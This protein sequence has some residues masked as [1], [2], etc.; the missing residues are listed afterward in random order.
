MDQDAAANR[1]D[2]PRTGPGGAAAANPS[3]AGSTGL[4][5][6]GIRDAAGLVVL[7][8]LEIVSRYA[9][10]ADGADVVELLARV[11]REAAVA[12]RC[13]RLVFAYPQWL[14]L[15]AAHSARVRQG[16]AG[17]AEVRGAEPTA[18]ADDQYV[19]AAAAGPVEHAEDRS[20]QP[21]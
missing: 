1:G 20:Q 6:F 12:A 17:A 13:R 14:P 21:F 18:Y 4:I 15:V 9:N 10:Q 19:T 11:S 8:Q 5:P 3:A 7:A 2:Q 16:R